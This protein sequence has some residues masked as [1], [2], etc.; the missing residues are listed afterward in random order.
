MKSCIIFNPAARGE[1]AQL[2]RR[3]LE[4]I[5]DQAAFKPTWAPGVATDLA[6]AAVE[7]GFENIIAAGGDGTLNEVLNG[8]GKAKDGFKKARL[9][10]LPLGTI[11]VFAKELGLP[12]KVDQAW[13]VV[14]RGNHRDVDLPYANFKSDGE[15]QRRY[16][17]QLAGAGLDAEAIALVDW[18]SKR[19]FRNLAYVFA[20]VRALFR[21]QHRIQVTAG[22]RTETGELILIGNGRY[23]GGRL[24]VF[25]DARL[26]DGRIDVCVFPNVGFHTCLRFGFWLFVERYWTSTPLPCFQAEKISLTSSTDARFEVEGDLAGPLPL[27]IGVQPR[28]LRVICP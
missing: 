25:A 12:E 3:F 4:D 7:E 9:G 8:I 10:I 15:Q 22:D 13:E 27:E 19:R 1:K 5:G 18:E 26:D 24:P 11:N 2:F 21:K 23:Y 14:R 17:A 16:F 20:G 28:G 6:K